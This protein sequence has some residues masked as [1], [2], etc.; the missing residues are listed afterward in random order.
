MLSVDAVLVVYAFHEFTHPDAM[1]AGIAGALKPGGRLGVLD[2]SA[3]L[4]MRPTEYM[5]GHRLPQEML[6]ERVTH[7][8][9]RLI[10]FDSDFAGTPDG[11]QYYFAVFEKPTE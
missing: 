3:R 4:G 9:L 11:T 5:D 6:I 8:G 10:S 7:A 2:R 1:M